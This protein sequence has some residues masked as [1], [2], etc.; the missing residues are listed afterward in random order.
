MFNDTPNK[1]EK[2]KKKKMMMKKK[3]KKKDM[4]SEFRSYLNATI[5]QNCPVTHQIML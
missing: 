5:S 1:R 4:K 3:K 2:K